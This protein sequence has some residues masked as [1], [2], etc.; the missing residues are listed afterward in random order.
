MT[1]LRFAL[2]SGWTE[3]ALCP[4]TTSHHAPVHPSFVARSRESPRW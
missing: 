1:I 3:T 4:A 2:T